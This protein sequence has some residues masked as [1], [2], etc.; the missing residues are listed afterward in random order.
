MPQPY[1]EG[2]YYLAVGRHSTAMALLPKIDQAIGQLR[3]NGQLA[4][5]LK[6]Y[7]ARD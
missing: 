6:K 2:A 1:Y 7:D 3:E 4:A 5:L